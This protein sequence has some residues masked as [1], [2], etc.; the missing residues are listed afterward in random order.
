M[1][2]EGDEY[3]KYYAKIQKTM[4]KLAKNAEFGY[5]F[6]SLASLANLLKY[7]CNLAKDIYET[8]KNKGDL[9]PTILH[10]KKVLKALNSFVK[11]YEKQWLKEAKG[12][13]YEKQNIRLGGLKERLRFVIDLL[14]SYQNG[15][16]SKI[17]ELEE[18]QII[19]NMCGHPLAPG[20]DVVCDYRSIVS[21]GKLNEL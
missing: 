19:S 11:V 16:I 10:A 9:T 14:T 15:E 7:K 1:E 2:I 6:A 4:Q 21:A 20:R 3:V 5:I 17:D 18:I 8:Y 13:G 12:M